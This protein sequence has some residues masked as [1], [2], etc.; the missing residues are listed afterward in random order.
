M[1]SQ[2]TFEKLVKKMFK[3]LGVKEDKI[4]SMISKVL[5]H[6]EKKLI[7]TNKGLIETLNKLIEVDQKIGAANT[8]SLDPDNKILYN[9]FKENLGIL[10]TSIFRNNI[11]KTLF[12]KE[13]LTLMNQKITI[14]NSIITKPVEKAG[15]VTLG[16]PVEKAGLATLGKPVEKANK[17]IVNEKVEKANKEIANEKVEKA[18]K[19]IANE[20]VEKANKEIVN[21]KVE[22]ANKEIANEKVERLKNQPRLFKMDSEDS[23]SDDEDEDD[24]PQE[25]VDNTTTELGPVTQSDE[26]QKKENKP[27]LDEEKKYLNCVGAKKDNQ[28][29]YWNK[30][31]DETTNDRKKT[32]QNEKICQQGTVKRRIVEYK[33]KK[34]NNNKKYYNK[35]LKYKTKYVNLKKSIH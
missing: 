1:T 35:Y 29:Y 27:T 12:S 21:E 32:P 7:I 18:N 11:N 24:A 13:L 17:E 22:K 3:A 31:T 30:W 5:N 8:S 25:K 19:E 6:D 33:N 10:Q 20:K 9:S 16:K 4:G 23:S 15:L 14:L 28:E 26:I 34:N 2:I